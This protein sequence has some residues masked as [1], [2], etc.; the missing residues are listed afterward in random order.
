M[1][2]VIIKFES[3][4]R[5]GIIAAGS[6]LSDA[7]R[8]LGVKITGDCFDPETEHECVMK[9]SAGSELLSS[10]TQTELEQLSSTARKNGERLACQ[11]IIEKP[12]EIVIMS[13]KKKQEE[14]K[15][16]ETKAE[17]KADEFKKEFEE[18]PLDK[19]IASLLE[20]EAIALGETFSYVLNSPYKAVGK[21][22][23]VMADFGF[24]MDK[25]DHDAKRPAEHVNQE[26]ENGDGEKGSDKKKS[27]PKTKSKTTA[28]RTSTKK[29]TAAKPKAASENKPENEGPETEEKSDGD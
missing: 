1:K 8:R 26:S 27:A 9:I 18:M 24:K 5:E 4:G 20:L 25:A 12:G 19:K 17:E 13:V 29:T 7:A 22:M 28:K 16:E 11:T 10:P 6:Y 21:V 23:D 3:E 15:S 2:E 14:T